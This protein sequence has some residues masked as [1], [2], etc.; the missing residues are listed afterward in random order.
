MGRQVKESLTVSPYLLWFLIHGTQTG[1]ATLIFQ[2]RI[3]QGAEMDSWVSLLAVGLCFHL[4][5]GMIFYVLRHSADGDMM[6]LHRRLFGKGLGKAVTIGFYGYILLFAVHEFRSYV[7]VIHVWVF[8]HMPLRVLSFLFVLTASYLVSGGLRVIA[9]IS[10]VCVALPTLLIPTLYFPLKYAHWS[11]FLPLFNHGARDYLVSAGHSLSPFLGIEF[12]LL[13][14]P[15]VKNKP[16][17]RKWAHVANAHSIV[18]YLFILFVT[19]AFFNIRQLEHTIWPT[20]ILSKVIRF[21]FMERFD[22]IY[23][24]AWL[25]VIMPRCCVAI[26][27]GV[28]VLRSTFALRARPALWITSGAVIAAMLPLK[29]PMTIE[30]LDFLLSAA[31]GILLLGYIPLLF[32]WVFAVKHFKNKAGGGN[33]SLENG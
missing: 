15:F 8:P 10:L 1:T 2:S 20:L 4:L 5:I 19:F 16:Q 23:I 32:L 27:G 25:L 7:E 3:I 14:Y 24:F 9:G 33:E 13:L 17:A 30:K 31:G 18:I 29:S 21:P 6:S 11:N 26:W 12:L 28:R 22:Y